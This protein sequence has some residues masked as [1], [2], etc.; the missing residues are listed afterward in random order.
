MEKF[1]KV[2]VANL[3]DKKLNLRPE[4]FK[5][6]SKGCRCEN[7]SGKGTI[8]VSLDFLGSSLKV[9][10]TCNGRGLNTDASEIRSRG[11]SFSDILNMSINELLASEIWPEFE[12]ELRTA[13][14]MGLG[15]LKAGQNGNHL[16]GG[17][18]QRLILVS[19]LLDKKSE[20]LVYL[21]DEPG[22]GL[23]HDDSAKFVSLIDELVALGNSV[24]MIEH[25]PSI[26]VKSDWLIEL[27]PGGGESGGSIIYEGPPQGIGSH[28]DTPTIRILKSLQ[29][30]YG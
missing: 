22:R 13:V 18:K 25:N 11:F 15:Y 29:N 20:N 7:C 14:R 8:T 28:E 2:F 24:I 3:D 23:H 12:F 10:D 27:G 17:E 26:I 30:R 6:T 21:F 9:C 1:R 16:S 19:K 4:Y 5:L